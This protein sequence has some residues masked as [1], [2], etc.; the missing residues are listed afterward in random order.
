MSEEVVYICW[1]CGDPFSLTEGRTLYTDEGNLTLCPNCG[2][3]DIEEGKRCKIC[4]DIHHEYEL[5]SG[6]CKGCFEDAVSAYKSC[7]SSLMPWEREVL[8][9]EYGNI[10]ITER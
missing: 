6:V 8:D 10:D 2:S 9:D 4:R 3:S 7:L 5:R 1:H